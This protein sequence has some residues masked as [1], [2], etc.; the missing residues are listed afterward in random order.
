[1]YSSF[2]HTA[3]IGLDVS[4]ESREALFAEA[5]RGLFQSW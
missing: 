3:D 2:E 4:A 1:M 5:A